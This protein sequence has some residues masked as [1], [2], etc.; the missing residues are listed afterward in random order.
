[1]KSRTEIEKIAAYGFKVI[2]SDDSG[3][4]GIMR[5]APFDKT[6]IVW[7]FIDRHVSVSPRNHTPSWIDMC[8][9]KDLFY[10][11][12]DEV[13]QC[14]PKK[15]EYVNINKNCLHLWEGRLV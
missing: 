10:N 15:S 2:E 4:M 14:H 6:S 1:M 3:G 5:M 7:T 8:I 11:E 12:E 13:W 9:I